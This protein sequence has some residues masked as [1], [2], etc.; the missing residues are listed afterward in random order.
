MWA[1]GFFLGKE[2]WVRGRCV[3]E[4]RCK[5]RSCPLHRLSSSH[6]ALGRDADLGAPVGVGEQGRVV[7]PMQRCLVTHKTKGH[8]VFFPINADFP[9]HFFFWDSAFSFVKAKVSENSRFACSGNNRGCKTT[10]L[11]CRG[12]IS[13]GLTLKSKLNTKPFPF[14]SSEYSVLSAMLACY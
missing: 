5:A 12:T 13:P 10:G 1:R 11:L 8:A 14:P 6:P 9:N 4:T 3:P 7:H 2:G